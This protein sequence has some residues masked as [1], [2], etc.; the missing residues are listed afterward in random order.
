MFTCHDLSPALAASGIWQQML[1]A[2]RMDRPG[3]QCGATLDLCGPSTTI[4]L[5]FDAPRSAAHPGYR[6]SVTIT[7]DTGVLRIAAQRCSPDR[8]LAALHSLTTTSATG[9]IAPRAFPHAPD[10]S[11]HPGGENPAGTLDGVLTLDRGI[12]A[13]TR[14]E[15]GGARPGRPVA[16]LAIT[17]AALSRCEDAWAHG[18][19]FLRAW[20]QDH[21]SP[22]RTAEG[23]LASP[24]PAT[25]V[26]PRSGG[27]FRTP[28]PAYRSG[29]SRTATGRAAS[30]AAR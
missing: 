20:I 17:P 28:R 25:P 21:R 22:R 29:G 18:V 6:G 10:W 3:V 4:G 14:V 2:L 27:R 30:G 11:W 7:S 12:T 15:R 13:T 1:D 23:A 19:G 24:P 26:S 9:S 16:V 8:W 5:R